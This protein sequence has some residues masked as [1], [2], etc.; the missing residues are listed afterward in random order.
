M[1]LF[2]RTALFLCLGSGLL[3]TQTPGGAPTPNAAP[4]QSADTNAELSSAQ[5]LAQ[6]GKYDEAIAQLQ[7]MAART[8]KLKGLSHAI[9]LVYYKKGDYLK[10]ADSFKQAIAE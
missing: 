4:T 10:A 5:R 2:I 1:L 8:P 9:G 7:A 6:Q 3:T